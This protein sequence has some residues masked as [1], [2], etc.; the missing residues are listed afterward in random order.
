VGEA[1]LSRP[2]ANA[3]A[4]ALSTSPSCACG[5]LRGTWLRGEPEGRGPCSALLGYASLRGTWLR[6][7][8]EAR[9]P[10]SALLGY[11]SLRGTWPEGFAVRPSP[12][13]RASASTLR[14]FRSRARSR[15]GSRRRPSLLRP[16]PSARCPR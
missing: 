16:P 1:P 10:C 11:A 7:E 14:G 6:G 3:P 5:S 12:C 13:A 2:V 4:A 9:G 15:A 8:P